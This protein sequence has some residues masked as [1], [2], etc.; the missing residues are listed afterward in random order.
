MEPA[1]HSDINQQ[2][3]VYRAWL[4]AGEATQLF[5]RLQNE[6][7]WQQH[8]IQ[9]FGKRC[10]EP[11]LSLWVGDEDCAYR[12]SGRWREPSPW[13]DYLLAL[14]QALEQRVQQPFNSVLLNYYRDGADYMGWHSDNEKQLGSVPVIA[15]LSLG[16]ARRFLFRHKLNNE[17]REYLLENGD[18]L[19]MNQL[20]QQQWQH[21]LPKMLKVKRPRINLT[22]RYTMNLS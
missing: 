15:S 19:L 12:Y 8:H 7:P 2:L 9:V 21:S 10:L 18:M 13:P 6:L 1:T 17:R 3:L 4:N 5:Q 14:K 20:S 22:F 11:R 16:E